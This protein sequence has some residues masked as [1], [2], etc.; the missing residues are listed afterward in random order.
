MFLDRDRTD[1]RGSL[2]VYSRTVS[3]TAP[4]KPVRGGDHETGPAEA[5]ASWRLLAWSMRRL[6]QGVLSRAFGRLADVRLPRALRPLVLGGFARLVGVDLS[7]AEHA[8]AEYPTLDAFFVRRLRPGRRPMPSDPDAMVSPVDGSVSGSGTVEEGQLI[9]AKGLRY[10]VSELLGDV[11]LAARFDDGWYATLYLSPRDY[12][13]IHAPCAGAVSWAR[14]EP[15]RLLPVN[16]PLAAVEPRLFARN[17]RLSCILET[18]PGSV[19]VV[20]VGAFNVGRISAAFDP[21]WAGPAVGVTNRRG[22]RPANR[23]YEPPVPV[24]RGDEL[25]AFHLGSTVVVLAAPGVAVPAESRPL[26]TPIRVGEILA[27]G[28]V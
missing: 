26:G 18:G 28:A 22:A 12:H 11:D 4:S 19:A 10:T 1:R 15:G 24:A 8:P 16:R 23:V 20:A 14:H 7:E 27:A 6:P 5:P 25:M 17:E 2:T 9:Q 3:E 21:S 13:R